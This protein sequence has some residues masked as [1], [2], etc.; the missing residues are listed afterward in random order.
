M[1]NKKSRF[2]VPRDPCE[3][4]S[5]KCMPVDVHLYLDGRMKLIYV[6]WIGNSVGNMEP[7]F[8]WS[9][10]NFGKIITTTPPPTR[11]HHRGISY[12]WIWKVR[13]VT[14][15]WNRR[16]LLYAHR[17]NCVYICVCF[18]FGYH[19]LPPSNTNLYVSLLF[20]YRSLGAMA[21]LLSYRLSFLI[22]S[23]TES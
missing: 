20:S 21:E 5:L 8:T 1:P 4:R 22:R 14:W 17:R 12:W 10:E 15:R 6:S 23:A 18:Y 13:Y 7:F 11:R 3:G 9:I 2:I 19:S 16:A